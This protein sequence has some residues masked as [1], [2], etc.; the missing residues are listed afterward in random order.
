MPRDPTTDDELY[1][2]FSKLLSLL[3]LKFGYGNNCWNCCQ[4]LE[5]ISQQLQNLQTEVRHL[6]QVV[7]QGFEDMKSA[8][9]KPTFPTETSLKKVEEKSSSSEDE[10][11]CFSQENP[12]FS[13]TGIFPKR[14]SD[15]KPKLEQPSRVDSMN[16]SPEERI[17]SRERDSKVDS[18]ILVVQDSSSLPRDRK[19]CDCVNSRRSSYQKNILVEKDNNID[20]ASS[21]LDDLRFQ[22]SL[23]PTNA[24]L[25]KD[26][27]AFDVTKT[28]DETLDSR[29]K[30]KARTEETS[31]EMHRQRKVAKGPVSSQKFG[32]IARG[33]DNACDYVSFSQT[34]SPA[35]EITTC[36][37]KKSTERILE[38]LPNENSTPKV[39]TEYID[40]NGNRLCA[41]PVIRSKEDR[42]KLKGSTCTECQKT[43]NCLA[44]DNEERCKEMIQKYSRHRHCHTPPETPEFWFDISF[45][46]TETVPPESPLV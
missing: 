43:W 23:T 4:N 44:H 17:L 29:H 37:M 3:N 35:K 7:F 5:S 42:M 11:T 8:T 31:C 40:N 15:G 12:V 10:I 27:C 46:E 1:S 2:L 9:K 34:P 14:I 30:H 33:R 22:Q 45:P 36:E 32:K 19:S 41:N 28:K 16:T 39:T 26:C 13:P 25:S 6:Q 24:E 21:S 18:H 38:H 20:D